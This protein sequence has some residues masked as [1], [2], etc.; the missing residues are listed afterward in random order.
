MGKKFQ[1]I[2]LDRVISKVYRD[3]G[4]EEFSETDI[5][6]WVGEALEGIGAIDLQEE[7]VAYIEV[8]NYSAALPNGLTSIIQVAKDNSWTP[9]NK[10]LCPA[11]I[12]LD[13]DV[14]QITSES[15]QDQ[16][17]CGAFQGVPLG[18][19]GLFIDDSEIAYYRPYFDLQYE[20]IDW[21]DSHQYQNYS[22]VRLSN[23][24]YFGTLVHQEETTLY[25]SSADE[26]TIN[27]D[28]IRT[29][30]KEGSVAIAY[31][32]QRVDEETGYPLV[33]DDYS[34]LSAITYY[35]TWKYMARMWYMGKEGYERKMRESESQWQWYCKQAS[36]LAFGPYGVDEHQN[37]MEQSYRMIPDRNSYYGF[38]G[39]LGKPDNTAWKDAD[40]RNN[41][42]NLRGI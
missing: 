35:I 33:P 3:L 28:T 21:C 41:Q 1:Y 26:Y 14:T 18:C 10:T 19:D 8:K 38:F 6:E 37:L 24:S 22:P 32:R 9:E 13:T 29:S 20:Y 4:L 15:T 25:N 31:N 39:K 5:I 36:N 2:P 42:Y 23:H 17:G 7:A 12:M 34:V 16:L 27:N 30:F 40:G 11:S